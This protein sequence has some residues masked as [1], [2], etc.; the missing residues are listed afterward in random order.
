MLGRGWLS[1][2]ESFW[3]LLGQSQVVKVKKEEEEGKEEGEGEF[4]GVGVLGRMLSEIV[5]Q[6]EGGVGYS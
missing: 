4:M 3:M 5:E 6:V 2:I 1:V